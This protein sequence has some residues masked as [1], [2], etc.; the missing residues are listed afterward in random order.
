M[1]DIPAATGGL[2]SAPDRAALGGGLPGGVVEKSTVRGEMLENK[3]FMIPTDCL[4]QSK[5]TMD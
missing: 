2:L 4:A 1:F 5:V 3:S